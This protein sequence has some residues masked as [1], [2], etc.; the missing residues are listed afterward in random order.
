MSSSVN[1]DRSLAI[2]AGDP[3]DV[4]RGTHAFPNDDR[5]RR[6]RVFRRPSQQLLREVQGVL[7]HIVANHPFGG[8]EG[9]L[10][11]VCAES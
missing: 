8:E 9:R 1:I 10:V 7:P 5:V 4:I 3:G 6:E 2:F 11:S